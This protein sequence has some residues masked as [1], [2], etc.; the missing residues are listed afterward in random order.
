MINTLA[1]LTALIPQ[2]AQA[3]SCDN[4]VRIVSSQIHKGT[5]PV[6]AA[7]ILKFGWYSPDES[8]T[9]LVNAETGE[10]IEH[11]LE[12]IDDNESYFIRPANQLPAD[13]EI[14]FEVSHVEGG[15]MGGDLFQ[16]N[17]DTDLESP[18]APEIYSATLDI[19]EDIWGG[20]EWL[21]LQ[22]KNLE[23]GESVLIE[24]ADNDAFNDSET[25][26]VVDRSGLAHVGSD[27][28]GSN[29]LSDIETIEYVRASVIDIAGNFSAESKV[30][31]VY[32]DGPMLECRACSSA[33]GPL[34][35]LLPLFALPILGLR[36]RRKSF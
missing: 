15:F 25:T 7:L 22:L 4:G 2:E 16:T 27:P 28:C 20:W 18:D 8:V 19:S 21:Q 24:V 36:R 34:S 3:L 5:V 10:E 32:E 23:D 12:L 1:F 6:N 14:M 13:T 11:R 17:G 9:R 29:L 33:A 26:V 30:F 31:S 35:S